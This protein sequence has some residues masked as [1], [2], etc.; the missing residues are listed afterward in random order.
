MKKVFLAIGVVAAVLVALIVAL[1]FVID[2]NR[3]KDPLLKKVEENINGKVTLERIGLKLFPF[4]GLRLEKL[5]VTNL[6]DSPFGETPLLKLGEMDLRVHLKS[7]LKRKLVASLLL[8]KPEIQ[9]IKTKQGTN[10]DLLIK[11]KTETAPPPVAEKK[12]EPAPA[13][14]SL[15][16]DM[17][18]EKI[19]IKDGL[20]VYEDRTTPGAASG[21]SAMK[22]SGFRLEVTNAV[23]TD[24]SR[25]IGIDLGMRLFDAAKE[26]LSFQGWVAVDQKAKDALIKDAKLTIAGSPILF[27]VTVK[28]YEK[29]QRVD[30]NIS[31]PSFAMNS[32]YSLLPEAK[33]SL[34]P[35]SSLEGS[36][37][38]S[39]TANGTPKSMALKSTV[40][41]K[42]A[43]IRY[44][45][46]FEKPAGSTFDLSIDGNF[47]TGAVKIEGFALHL[48]SAAITGSGSLALAGSQDLTLHLTSNPI[49]LK[50]MITLSPENKALDI[51]GS[52]QMVFDARGPLSTPDALSMVGSLSSDKIR[53]DTYTLDKIVSSFSFSKKVANLKE[54]AFTLFEGRFSGTA[55]ADLNGA[56][57]VWD[58]SFQVTDLNVNT[59]LTQT[60]ALPDALLGKGSLGL[61]VKGQGS[62][63]PEI[64]K[65]VSGNLKLS[66]REG[67][68]RAFNL[69]PSLFSS[70][71]IDGMTKV[72][73]KIPSLRFSA[74]QAV[75]SLKSTPFNELAVE[76]TIQEGK[77]SLSQMNLSHK[78]QSVQMGGTVDLD[79]KLDMS[80]KYFLSREASAG[81]I[82]D[83]KIRSYLTDPEGRFLIPFKVTGDLRHPSIG[84]DTG[85]VK[86]L[87]AKA[88]TSYL[89]DQVKQKLAEETDKLKQKATD[90]AKAAA[91]QRAQELLKEGPKPA[92]IGNKL[93]SLF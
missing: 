30:A 78:D 85:Y 3:F 49:N 50:E 29:E 67:E 21:A 57:P 73:E 26:N 76:G 14:E 2:V 69:A 9:F 80:G 74:P 72:A 77:I 31:A 65:T 46:T 27:N 59:L 79:L 58:A 28:D 86:E 90:E 39:L 56:K 66:L 15:I 54:L 8:D 32:I 5:A 24:T 18:V 33:K 89:A 35:D 60:A 11:K 25:P 47:S 43:A 92:D 88:V 6:P 82:T 64:K 68:L 41:L 75:A 84:P 38:L 20:M 17:I 53:Y 45:K 36:L 93:K 48:L 1:P 23:L 42:Q 51:D 10:V 22:I 87:V 34:P 19:R 37:A 16:T 52:L 83:A 12:E 63:A 70:E 44:G 81:W 4:I 40:D 55:T 7:L 61:N 71:V 91:S 62:E 13:K